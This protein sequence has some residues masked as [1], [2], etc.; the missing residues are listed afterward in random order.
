MLEKLYTEYKY[1]SKKVVVFRK[2]KNPHTLL[3]LLLQNSYPRF[4]NISSK[5]KLGRSFYLHN[6]IHFNLLSTGALEVKVLS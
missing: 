6:V 3:K 4:R 1:A 2:K 5:I